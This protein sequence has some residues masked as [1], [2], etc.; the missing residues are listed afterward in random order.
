M[1]QFP[2][3]DNARGVWKLSEV[4]E[5]VYNGTWPNN[6]AMGLTAGSGLD[7]STSSLIERTN[8]SSG[9]QNTIF[10]NLSVLRSDGIGL[11]SLTRGL[12]AGGYLQPGS[13]KTNV[14]DYVTFSTE[15]SASD[16]GDLTEARY[17]MG[18]GSNSTRGVAMAGMAG[19]LSNVIDFVTIASTGNATDFGDDTVARRLQAGFSSSTRGFNAQGQTP[20]ILN[21]ITNITFATTGNATDF[22]D[23]TQT[24]K[25]AAGTSSSTRGVFA[26]GQNPYDVIEFIS[27]FSQGNA[28]D[29]GDLTVSRGY[30]AG[31]SNSV[32][33]QF[34]GG[35]APSQQNV[36]DQITISTTGNATDFGDLTSQK[37][38]VFGTSNAHGG[39]TDGFQGTR[40]ATFLDSGDFGLF[41][42]GNNGS[43]RSGIDQIKI[44]TT[45]DATNFGNLT[46]PTD[47]GQGVANETRGVFSNGNISS[48]RTN[49]VIDYVTFASGGNASDFGD[50]STGRGG[51]GGGISN[52]TRGMFVG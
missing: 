3:F 1:A 23:A 9:G 29:F 35:R 48:P 20:S 41:A 8:I 18:G 45:G 14:I 49:N 5:Q 4:Y 26:G 6:G 36:I 50:L 47:F 16:F 38:S 19:S 2:R 40:P 22:G 25:A 42:G 44:S 34:A 12:F 11:S 30:L 37:S 7:N 15:G 24:N 51:G 28:A 39:L 32:R 17:G 52:S 43:R 27:M 10:G 13:G 31:F 33:A 21:T 46:G